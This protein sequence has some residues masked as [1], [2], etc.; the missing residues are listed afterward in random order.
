[1]GVF[2]FPLALL[3]LL[4]LPGLWWV[5]RSAP[6]LP[7][8]LSFPAVRLLR[9][10]E[11]AR[12]E[13]RRTPWGVLLLRLT[14]VALGILVDDGW[15]AAADWAERRAAALALLDEAAGTGRRV[16]LLTTAPPAD[17]SPV[18]A[19][20]AVPAATLKPVIQSLSPKPWPV[21]RG[22]ALAQVPSFPGTAVW[23]TDGIEDGQGSA[24]AARLHRLGR[25]VLVDG[26]KAPAARLLLPP[27]STGAAGGWAI[28][29]RRAGGPD[30]MLFVRALDETGHVLTRKALPLPSGHDLGKGSLS[31]PD[32]LRPQRLDLEGPASVGTVVLLENRPGR[33][34]LVSGTS[35]Q[36]EVPLVSDLYYLER[37]FEPLVAMRRGTIEEMLGEDP[38]GREI[39]MLILADVG[40]LP[41]ETAR[42]L[43]SWIDR[44][45]VLV[46]F[47][48]PTLAGGEDSLLPVRLRLGERTTGGVLTWDQPLSLAPFEAGRPFAGLKVPAD[49]RVSAQVLAEP[50]AELDTR[51]WARL[52]DGTPL[53]TG[54]ALGQG[55]M[56]L[57]H[58][59][60]NAR[61]SNLA[62]SGLFVEMMQCLLD[63]GRSGSAVLTAS[64][65]PLELLDA[66]GRLHATRGVA[67]PLPGEGESLK[68]GP[69]HPPGYYGTPERRRAFNLSDHVRTL[70][71]LLPP[72]GSQKV[73]FADI[74]HPFDLS[75]WVLVVALMGGIADC[76]VVRL[77]GGGFG[78]GRTMTRGALVLVM[79][80]VTM[81]AAQAQSVP[82]T[83]EAFA[84]AAAL[85]TRLAHVRS[86]EADVDDIVRLGLKAL[87][88]VLAGRTA[89]VL[90]E[91]M[92]LDIEKDE[93]LFFPLLYW[94]V[95]DQPVPLSPAAAAK[96][97][98]YLRHG[99]LIVFD[100]R[101][102]SPWPGAWPGEGRLRALLGPGSLPPLTPLSPDHV[103]TRS[104]YLLSDWPGRLAGGPLWGV[105]EP[106]GNDH[107]LP[108]ILGS[109]DWAG[110]WAMSSGGRPLLPVLPDGERQR[111]MAYRFGINLV[112]Y[113]L[114]GNYKA[115]QVH[116]PA[117]LER[118]PR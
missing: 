107:V 3:L 77:M 99:G 24:L 116:L 42:R 17:G 114:T 74:G 75:P 34:G 29:V 9:G 104:F 30:E 84:L 98:H 57:I 112:M 60:A 37:A 39:S 8:R 94:P 52:T 14:V 102:A 67:Q 70:T 11:T 87:T 48:G 27:V 111:E 80:L 90:A 26:G 4:I 73:H 92:T 59:T 45:G 69:H 53:V 78:T 64:L 89:A 13:A 71:P 115:D 88:R 85:E 56:V 93:I 65:P 40:R 51:T 103:V 1:M 5:L 82:E 117:I 19:T 61:W 22:A 54:A 2:T 21:D 38:S 49:V 83:S 33:V 6:P 35:V 118:L 86:F 79:A 46:R 50:S 63:L 23:M 105:H 36:A 101:D 28:T 25:L 18:T 41:A 7:R 72:A 109:N 31:L 32:E 20:P 15:A 55:W 16:V 96:V 66:F 91:P 12:H 43:H 100:T 110:A 58:T 106:E 10:L 44:G 62:L 113:A 108:V 81:P 68:P 95:I 76:V 47:A 97:E